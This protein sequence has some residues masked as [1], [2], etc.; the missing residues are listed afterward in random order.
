MNMKK[1]FIAG[2]CI[3][4]VTGY[5]F[6][7]SFEVPATYSFKNKEEC[8]TFEKDILAASKWLFATPSDEQEA[9]RKQVAKFV[10]E[11]VL[12]SST[13]NAEMTSAI[14]DFENTN[15]GM[16]AL[17]FAGCSWY[18]LEN[19]YSADIRAKHRFAL[20]AMM[21]Y[22]KNNSLK[23]DKKMRELI[24]QNKDGKLDEWIEINMPLRS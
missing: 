1:F 2:L 24:K 7:Q 23:R 13:V 10:A 5:S 21:E 6:A 11:W 22:Y 16:M 9:K 17:Y 4:F 12:N 3:V 14:M 18:V 19:N 15:P 8:A 20:Q